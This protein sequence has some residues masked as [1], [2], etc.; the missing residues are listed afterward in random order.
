MREAKVSF[1]CSVIIDSFVQKYFVICK[2]KLVLSDNI[3]MHAQ[4]SL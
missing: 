1:S 4:A 2:V 3:K